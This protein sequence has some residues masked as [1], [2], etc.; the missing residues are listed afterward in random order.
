MN[1]TVFW[2]P[3]ALEDLARIVRHI[4][5]ENPIAAR[6]IGRELLLAGDSLAVFP[7]RGRTGRVPGTRELVPVQPYIIVYQ[8]GEEG[9]VT[10]IRVWHGA[11][12]R[13]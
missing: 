10:I 6:R 9:R 13:D 8:I 12:N 7:R 3:S 2:R 11:Q 5:E 4:T 1:D